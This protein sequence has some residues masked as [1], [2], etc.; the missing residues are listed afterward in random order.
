MFNLGGRE[1]GEAIVLRDVSPSLLNDNRWH[2]VSIGRPDRFRH[3]MM[4]DG[5]HFSSANTELLHGG[6]NAI[7]GGFGQAEDGLHLNLDSILF[8]G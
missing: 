5:K 3:T 7:G 1:G 8:L 6:A 2:S 4:V